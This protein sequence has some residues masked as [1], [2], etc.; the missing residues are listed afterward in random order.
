MISCHGLPNSKWFENNSKVQC[1]SYCDV[2]KV[3]AQ[4]T[5]KSTDR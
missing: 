4:Q 5:Q 3:I 2:L 1:D